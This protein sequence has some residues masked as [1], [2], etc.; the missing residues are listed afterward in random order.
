MGML[1]VYC[2]SGIRSGQAVSAL[3]SCG[4]SN[5]QN[6]GGIRSYGGPVEK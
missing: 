5:A 4:Y 3:K 1:P 2:L 6:I